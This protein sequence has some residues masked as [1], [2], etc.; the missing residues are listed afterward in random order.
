MNFYY[1]TV[2]EGLESSSSLAGHFSQWES[3]MRL[4]SDVC[5]TE[6]NLEGLSGLKDMFL[7]CSLI[8]TLGRR[9]DLL[10]FIYCRPE[11]SIPL[12]MSTYQG[13]S[14]HGSRLPSSHRKWS[15]RT[16]AS[17]TEPHVFT[18]SGAIYHYFYILYH[19]GQYNEGGEHTRVLVPRGR[20][21]WA[22]SWDWLPETINVLKK[23]FY[24][25]LKPK[26]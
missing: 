16:K 19:K 1:L 17:K 2:S 7:R 6:N 11:V 20:D 15:K 12:H 5:W 14:W 10:I 18:T 9:P 13:C 24:Q 22:P 25:S 3:L 4:Q 21:Y 8:M 26:L 23:L